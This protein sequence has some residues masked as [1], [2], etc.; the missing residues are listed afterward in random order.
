MFIPLACA[1]PLVTILLQLAPDDTRTNLRPKYSV[2][3]LAVSGTAHAAAPDTT[4]PQ[5]AAVQAAQALDRMDA[6]ADS[7]PSADD[8][9]AGAPCHC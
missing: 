4:S 6:A 8:K 9:P 5:L 2:T 3:V 7:G 1:D